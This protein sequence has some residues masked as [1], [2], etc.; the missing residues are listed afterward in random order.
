MVELLAGVEAK[1]VIELIN[2][3]DLRRLPRVPGQFAE[4]YGL[5]Q[6]LIQEIHPD[7]ENFLW[8]PVHFLINAK[9][10]EETDKIHAIKMIFSYSGFHMR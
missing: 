3:Y 2:D 6:G 1:K 7:H 8:T 4:H 10:I 9:E 5:L